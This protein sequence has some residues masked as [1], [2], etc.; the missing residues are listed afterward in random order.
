MSC[1]LLEKIR[2]IAGA[3][4]PKDQHDKFIARRWQLH[5]HT[6]KQT[7]YSLFSSCREFLVHSLEL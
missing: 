6:N 1:L 7:F 5:K 3:D 4:T 2:V